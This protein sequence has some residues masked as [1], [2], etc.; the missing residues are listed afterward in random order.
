M[1]RYKLVVQE[2][3]DVWYEVEGETEDDAYEMYYEGE[4]E[5]IDQQYSHMIDDSPEIVE[6]LDATDAEM[7]EAIKKANK[8]P[9]S[10]HK[11]YWSTDFKMFKEMNV[12]D[13]ED[14]L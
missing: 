5:M 8:D 2:V 9:H 1:P 13:E 10:P 14:I 11:M 3:Y 7:D 12:G 6:N 4:G